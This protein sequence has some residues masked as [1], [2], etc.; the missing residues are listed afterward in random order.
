MSAAEGGYSVLLS[1]LHR[2]SAPTLPL[3]TLQGLIVHYLA[4]LSPAPT[5][6]A[7][8]IVGSPLFRP[9]SL[10]KLDALKTSFRHA[11]HT[12]LHL[13]KDAPP[14]VFLPSLNVQLSAWLVA[15]LR[16]LEGGHA[17][18]RLACCSG[19]LLGVEDILKRLPSKQRDV[20]SSVQDEIVLAF[21]DLIDL[22]TSSDSWRKEFRPE[23]EAG[24]EDALT[25]SLI[26]SAEALLAVL[27]EKFVALPLQQTL[28]LLVHTINKSFM[29]GMF[30]SSFKSSTEHHP[31]YKIH[32]KQG[33]PA[34]QDVHKV[35]SSPAMSNMGSLSRLCSRSITLFVDHRPK[36]ALPRVQETFL[37]LE[38]I[39][40]N[41][42]LGWLASDLAGA[43]EESIAAETRK[44]TESIWTILK[45]LLFSTIMIV[46]AGLSA[47][48]YVPPEIGHAAPSLALA[49]LRSLYHLAFVIEKFGGA[50]HSAFP[51][52]KRAFYLPLDVLAGHKAESEHL[53]QQ[54][55]EESWSN[56]YD[57]SHPVQRA[58]KA[59]ALSTI[60]QLI[61]VLPTSGI[62]TYVLPF[63]SPHL[64]DAR[65]HDVFEAAH[66]VVLAIFSHYHHTQVTSSTSPSGAEREPE[67]AMSPAIMVP[68]YTRCLIENSA[69]DRLNASQ[70]RLAFAALVKSASASGD[71][72]L[73]WFCIDSLLTA[74][75]ASSPAFDEDRVHRLYL[76]LVS[77]VSSLPLDLLSRALLEVDGIIEG[78]ENDDIKRDELLEAL[79]Q[80]IINNVGD[81]EKEFAVCW[82]NERR[83]KW[84]HRTRLAIA[85]QRRTEKD[86]ED[87]ILQ[88]SEIPSRL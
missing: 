19:L 11:V 76:A 73:A 47:V 53:V 60:E 14:S 83:V 37:C 46:E 24:E 48:V 50:G 20:E 85:R 68:F 71:H 31:E 77:S 78:V 75:R 40:R 51:E 67:R 35:S 25:L 84:A 54:L 43:T 64:D 39:S 4:R 82:W 13:L 49:V 62:E 41:V 1:S 80:E 88:E 21:A 29:S 22:F 18:A 52:L 9:F 74:C 26:T 15:I 28:A 36:L 7:A 33:A 69:K 5:P 58:K 3:S 61:P 16:G 34:F 27:P 12:K 70:L 59:F 32:V 6:L 56:A 44:L 63:C 65:Y 66:S 86:E 10:T 2:A 55:C 38:S 72:A 23:T 45:T 42:E 57:L 87:D 8:T 30:L 17:I 81:A 79:F